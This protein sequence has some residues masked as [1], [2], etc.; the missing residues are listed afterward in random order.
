MFGPNTELLWYSGAKCALSEMS[1]Y[2]LN[3]RP[4]KTQQPSRPPLATPKGF[5]DDDDNDVERE[6]SRHAS[7]NK[8]LKEV[9]T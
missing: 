9:V 8:S 1:K 2:G 7:K 6:I 4:K 5:G 3:L